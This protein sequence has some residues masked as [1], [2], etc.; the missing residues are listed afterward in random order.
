MAS[1]QAISKVEEKAFARARENGHDIPGPFSV[2]PVMRRATC[3][4]CGTSMTY[5]VESPQKTLTGMPLFYSCHMMTQRVSDGTI[6]I[7]DK[8]LQKRLRA[9]F[10]RELRR[11]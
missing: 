7:A 4:V 2:N 1:E 11:A 9:K 8:A 6:A 3:S 10:A 5:Q